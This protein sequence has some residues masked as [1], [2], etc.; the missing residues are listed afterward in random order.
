VSNFEPQLF[1]NIAAVQAH[2][3]E[4]LIRYRCT[5]AEVLRKLAT[6]Y[7]LAALKQLDVSERD[8]LAGIAEGL[9]AAAA[10]VDV[11]EAVVA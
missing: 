8:H 11:T 7:E 1:E 2:C 4:Q 3:A 5:E 10:R 9:R 6:D